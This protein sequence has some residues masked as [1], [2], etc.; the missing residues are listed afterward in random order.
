[1]DKQEHESCAKVFGERLTGL[2]KERGVGK[3][4]LGQVV[5]VSRSTIASWCDGKTVP[6]INKFLNL[7]MFFDVKSDYLAGL[8]DEED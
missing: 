4:E 1:M 6:Y 3:A 5:G 2:M 8:I 7:V